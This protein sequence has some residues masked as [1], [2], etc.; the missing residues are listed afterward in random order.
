MKEI[1]HNSLYAWILASRPKTLT[2]SAT[3]IIIGSALAYM[4]GKFNWKPA[5]ACLLFASLMQ[6][7]ANLI[8]D[9]I[10]FLKGIDSKDR[11]GPERTVAQGWLSARAI[12]IGIGITL[13]MACLIGCTLIIYGGWQLIFIGVICVLFA[14]LYTGGPYSLSYHGWGD[15][16]VIVFFGFVPVGG[17]YY[18]QALDYT[19][20]TFIASLV[21]GLVIDTMLVVNNYR[22]RDTDSESGKRTII[23]RFG[24][25]F[26]SRLYFSLGVIAVLLCSWFATEGHWFAAILPLLYLLPHYFTWREMIKIHNGAALNKIFAENSRNM[27]L[28]GFLLSVGFIL[29]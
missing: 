5:L 28:M 20:D 3:P 16:L 12:K 24:E 23:V 10:D 8:N 9:L 6:I 19:I 1:K 14:F 18:V 25:R 26:G 17:T 7:A 15:L 29:G 4:N 13:I 22:D 2:A 21:C 11:I 27:L